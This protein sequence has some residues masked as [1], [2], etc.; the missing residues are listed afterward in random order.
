MFNKFRKNVAHWGAAMLA[1]LG[2]G[3]LTP[4]DIST[5][6]GYQ[7]QRDFRSEEYQQMLINAAQAKRDRKNAKRAEDTSI[8][9]SNYHFLSRIGSDKVRLIHPSY[10]G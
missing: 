7:R 1:G 9:I 8:A 3:G 10:A 6:G 5:Q 4:S 2:L